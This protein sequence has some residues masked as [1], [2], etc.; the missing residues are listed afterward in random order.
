MAVV[1]SCLIGV[2]GCGAGSKSLT[3]AEFVNQGNEICENAQEAREKV[4]ASDAEKFN[5]KGDVPA[6]QSA[7][8]VHSLPPYEEAAEELADLGAPAGIEKEVEELTEAMEEAAARAQQAPQTAVES[9]IQF[10][11]AN[12]KAKKIGLDKCSI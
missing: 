8:M 4:I 12:E 11:E 1:V 3:K 2:S 10:K 7:M 6:Q 5:P 9:D